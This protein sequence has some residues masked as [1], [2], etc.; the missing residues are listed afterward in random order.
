M[1]SHVFNDDSPPSSPSKYLWS[2][3]L[4]MVL[5]GRLGIVDHPLLIYRFKYIKYTI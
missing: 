5:V 4:L 3:L 1:A 2:N